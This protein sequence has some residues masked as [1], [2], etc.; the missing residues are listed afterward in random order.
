MTATRLLFTLCILVNAGCG[1]DAV[2]TDD[3]APADFASRSDLAARDLAVTTDAPPAG[4]DMTDARD[5]SPVPDL[6]ALPDLT[7]VPDLV[8]PPDLTQIGGA[9]A[10]GNAFF[11]KYTTPF[12]CA[13]AGM[14]L[15][16]P[17]VCPLLLDPVCG[18]DGV[19]YDNECLANGAGTDILKKGKC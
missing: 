8:I 3:A 4:I 5:L 19:N 1:G 12:S 14:C 9:C 11:C 16:R 13:G 6:V 2:S 15:P 10:C 7:L 17:R 18:C